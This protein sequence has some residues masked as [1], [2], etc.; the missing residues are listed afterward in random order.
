MMEMIAS[1]FT[2]VK[3]FASILFSFIVT[4][5]AV[6]TYRRAR[7][8]LL[9]P[10]RSEVIKK[11][12][13]IF[14]DLLSILK[15]DNLI[16]KSNNM[17]EELITLNCVIQLHELGFIQKDPDEMKKFMLENRSGVIFLEGVTTLRDFE[18]VQTF[19][20]TT[21][22][23]FKDLSALK[24]E[25][26]KNGEYK[27][28]TLAYGKEYQEFQKE[29]Y[30]FYDH[31]LIPTQMHDKLDRIIEIDNYN[32]MEAIPRVINSFLE[33]VYRKN[34]KNEKVHLNLKGVYNSFNRERRAFTHVVKEL[35]DIIRDYLKIDMEW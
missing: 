4:I 9:Q 14:L 13:S 33:D 16:A 11:Q 18:V 24:Y 8:T 25:E 28:D 32:I 6:K 10:L 19:E 12:T 22:D 1:N 21:E 26:L 15:D 35:K 31:I 20:N 29:F 34:Q 5:I 23:K 7:L 17:Y 30:S 2:M 27:I 3:D